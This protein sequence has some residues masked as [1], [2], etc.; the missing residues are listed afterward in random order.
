MTNTC[1]FDG[2]GGEVVSRQMCRRHYNDWYRQ[3]EKESGPVVETAPEPPVEQPP[4]PSQA[5]VQV[6]LPY[7][8][9]EHMPEECNMRDVCKYLV[10]MSTVVLA[11]H[12][13]HPNRAKI[14]EKMQENKRIA[15][16]SDEQ[17]RSRE[18]YE[19]NPVHKL[20]QDEKFHCIRTLPPDISRKLFPHL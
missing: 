19:A 16:M 3:Q 1:R 14:E 12:P 13:K 9:F 2:C 4:E 17:F 18:L 10:N 7:P 8:N 6:D 11:Q 20:T 15:D 5:P